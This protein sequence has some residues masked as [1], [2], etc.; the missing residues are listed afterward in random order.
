[1][2]DATLNL[3]GYMRE[4]LSLLSR[5]RLRTSEAVCA[6]EPICLSAT[7]AIGSLQPVGPPL[8]KTGTWEGFHVR[9][10][11]HH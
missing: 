1:M 4:S 6:S 5:C 10:G 3:L 7:E 8:R 2:S 9:K 11:C